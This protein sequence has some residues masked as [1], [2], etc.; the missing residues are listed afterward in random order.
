MQ[1]MPTT[2]NLKNEALAKLTVGLCANCCRS[3]SY[4]AARSR[5]VRPRNIREKTL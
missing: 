1:D 4:Q 3:V 5:L 2:P